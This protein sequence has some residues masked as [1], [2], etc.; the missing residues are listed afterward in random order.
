MLISLLM[1]LAMVIGQTPLVKSV[2][3]AEEDSFIEKV[4]DE[5]SENT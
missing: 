5:I 4:K 2:Q 1:A 3:A